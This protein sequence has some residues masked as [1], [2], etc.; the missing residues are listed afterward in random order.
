MRKT[1]LVL[2][3]AAACGGGHGK[4]DGGTGHDDAPKVYMD[5]PGPD[6]PALVACTP[7]NGTTVK[8]RQIGQVSGSAVL[9]TSPPNDGRLFVIEQAGRIRIFENEQ[10]RPTPYLDW[11][12]HIVGG[13]GAS[14][15]EQGLLGLAF[16][17]QFAY[18]GQFF[19]Y[20]TKSGADVVARCSASADPYV[21]NPTC[22]DI[23]SIQDPYSNHN[24]GMIEFG[25]KDGYLYIGDGDGGS[26]GDPQRTAQDTNKLLG[27]ILRIDVNSEANGKK[28]AIPA[29]NPFATSGGAPEV[30]I[31]GL[32]NPWRW[33]FDKATGDLWIGDVGQDAYEELD[34]LKYG[35]QAGKNLGWSKFEGNHCYASNYT[36]CADTDVNANGFTGPVYE[37]THNSGWIS[38][39]GGA[40]YSGSC[41]PDLAGKYFFIDYGAHQLM[42]AT[43][44]GDGS[45]T[46]TGLTGTWPQSPSSLHADARGEL[47]LTTT[48]GRVYQIEAGP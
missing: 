47:Y 35:D 20:Y 31:Y 12:S 40:V 18:N 5:A 15:S 19:I 46:V 32:R 8:V 10:L 22:D 29:D 41:F 16:H 30:Y 3:L 38:V 37:R 14:G 26:A 36:P 24:G 33:S 42:S 44:N 34:V 25:P 2:V 1:A 23:L 21:A 27:K 6:A 17:P 48:A 9:A 45:V 4:K 13:D 7:T 43:L 39:I 11:S 28:Y